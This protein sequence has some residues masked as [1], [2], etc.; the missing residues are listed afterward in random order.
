MNFTDIHLL[1]NI[2]LY[3]SLCTAVENMAGW[4]TSQTFLSCPLSSPPPSP[5]S[6]PPVFEKSRENLSRGPCLSLS[7][8][9]LEAAV[10]LWDCLFELS[11]SEFVTVRSKE[12]AALTERRTSDYGEEGPD[13]THPWG[14]ND[15]PLSETTNLIHKAWVH[16]RCPLS[17]KLSNFVTSVYYLH[18]SR[19]NKHVICAAFPGT[20]THHLHWQHTQRIKPLGQSNVVFLHHTH[21]NHK[22]ADWSSS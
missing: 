8:S 5:P 16:V 20:P 11:K 12:D 6:T 13:Q 18:P 22:E 4:S 9:A 14:S 21:M 15:E 10:L 19:V 2:G 3:P 7:L 1:T 17:H